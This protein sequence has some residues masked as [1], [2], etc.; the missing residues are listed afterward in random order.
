M[1]AWLPEWLF[2]GQLLIYAIL[3][4]ALIVLTI[5]WKQTP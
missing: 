2:E 1:S 4:A 5:V 3:A